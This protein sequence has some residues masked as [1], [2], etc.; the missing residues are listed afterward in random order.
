MTT[1]RRRDN[2]SLIAYSIGFVLLSCAG[3]WMVWQ[4]QTMG[5]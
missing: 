3:M 4:L 1:Q 5:M 2:L